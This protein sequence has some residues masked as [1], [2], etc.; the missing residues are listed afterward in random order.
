MLNIIKNNLI[1]NKKIYIIIL[2]LIL[3]IIILT[4]FFIVDEKVE[5][6]KVKQ[7]LA[8]VGITLTWPFPEQVGVYKLL[9]TDTDGEDTYHEDG[10]V[11]S[12][13]GNRSTGFHYGLDILS[14]DKSNVVCAAQAGTV[15][16]AGWNG[17]YGNCVIIQ[18]AGDYTT[19]YAHLDSIMVS[20]G[21]TVSV[22]QPL[23]IE[24]NTGGSR[25]THL[26]F[27]V[28]KNGETVDPAQF[29]NLDLTSK[30]GI[31]P[32][33]DVYQGG[34]GGS[35]SSG[36][37]TNKIKLTTEAWRYYASYATKPV[38]ALVESSSGGNSGTGTGNGTGTDSGS[39]TKNPETG[40]ADWPSKGTDKYVDY[41]GKKILIVNKNYGLSDDTIENYRYSSEGTEAEQKFNEM[42][43]AYGGF[44]SATRYRTYSDQVSNYDNEIT[45]TG[46]PEAYYWTAKPGYSEHHTGLAWD[47]GSVSSY[48]AG[49][50][51]KAKAIASEDIPVWLAANAHQYGFIIRYPDNK[52]DITG[53]GYEPW[54]VRYVGVELATELKNNGQ[55]L[56]EFFASQL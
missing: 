27:E 18:H 52:K 39:T 5:E 46:V 34:S 23:G 26:H 19:K 20:A 41:K 49:Q 22:S 3:I 40:S 51:A 16:L 42:E 31:I 35:G 37:K 25:G 7:Y 8:D 13:Y 32:T 21:Q 17:N 11:S 4:S 55:T 9:Y 10:A 28:G 1:N 45:N 56:E 6:F 48:G 38:E 36:T 43:S 54:H 29:F 44:S 24:G 33:G 53:Y 47:I 50:D 15:I 30:N 14:K 2:F 12:W